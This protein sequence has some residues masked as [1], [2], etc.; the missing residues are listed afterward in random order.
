[1]AIR[2]ETLVYPGPGGLFEG[3]VA[4][5]DAVASK[6]PGVLVLPNVLGQKEAD[7]RKAEALAQLGY[8]GFAVDLY[9]QG[10]RTTRESPDP[11]VYMNQL[12]ADRALLRDRL[13]AAL[14]T[15]KQ[16]PLVDAGRTAAIGF[17]FGGKCVLDMAR[18]GADLLGGVSFH[19]VYDRPDYV[20]AVPI[21]A[22]LLICHGWDDPLG[23]PEMVTA[24][25]AELTEAQADWQLHAYGH[26]GHAF[27]DRSTPA[28][29]RPGFGYADKADRR[30]WQAMDNFLAGLFA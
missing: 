23:P 13:H 22:K 30:S 18:S 7:T 16:H 5:D 26:A 21:R 19:G 29:T 14:A 25:A 20:S 28:G 6:R 8:V 12:N 15:L 10:K 27:T 1:M 2:R 11:A 9:G 3:A 17:C 4:W 24:L